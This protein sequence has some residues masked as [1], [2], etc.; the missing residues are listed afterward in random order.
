MVATAPAPEGL[1]RLTHLMY[2]LHAFSAL[3]GVISSAAVVTAFLSGWPSLIAV[4]A[5]LREA[6]RRP[7]HL[8]RIALQ[9]A[10]PH[11][12]VRGAVVS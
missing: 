2:A 7:R 4:G 12:L 3:M 1:V 8:S 5:Q 9:L 10:A 11:V 6:R